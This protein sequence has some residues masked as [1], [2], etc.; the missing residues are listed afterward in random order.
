MR[1]RLVRFRR[2]GLLRRWLFD[3]VLEIGERGR[4]RKRKVWDIN[5]YPIKVLNAFGSHS[6][7]IS[8]IYSVK[9][10]IICLVYVVISSM[11]LLPCAS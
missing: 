7:Y 1:R 2:G 4:G 10:V 3:C 11:V 5:R 8:F 9:P 6:T